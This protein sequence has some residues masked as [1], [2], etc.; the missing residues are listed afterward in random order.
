M[1]GVPG[2]ALTRSA[3]RATSPREWR[4]IFMFK[5][6]H[7]AA[8]AKLADESVPTVLEGTIEGRPMRLDVMLTGLAQSAGLA[9]FEARGEPY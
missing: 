4:G 8:V 2:A 6:E 1:G 5:P 9:F 7:Q 3:P